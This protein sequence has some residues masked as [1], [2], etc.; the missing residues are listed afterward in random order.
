[1]ELLLAFTLSCSAATKVAQS[2]AV[3]EI[4]NEHAIEII[5]E[6]QKVSPPNCKLPVIRKS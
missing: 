4:T 6:L 2:A 5:E 3:A 1:M